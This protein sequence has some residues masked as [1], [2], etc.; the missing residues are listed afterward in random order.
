[1]RRVHHDVDGTAVDVGLRLEVPVSSGGDRNA[2]G[3]AGVFFASSNAG[4][5]TLAGRLARDNPVAAI[6]YSATNVNMPG[7]LS[8]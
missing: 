4:S 6:V 3:R 7:W 8:E 5:L 1:M 2:A